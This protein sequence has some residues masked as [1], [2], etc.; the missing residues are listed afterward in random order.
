MTPA[1]PRPRTSR[2]RRVH[3]P[4][5]TTCGAHD[6]GSEGAGGSTAA[7]AAVRRLAF[8]GS[9]AAGSGEACA[10]GTS[11]WRG[12]A[13]LGKGAAAAG[14][15]VG[16]TAGG[17][18][19]AVGTSVASGAVADVGVGAVLAKAGNSASSLP[20]MLR[21]TRKVPSTI[22]TDAAHTAL[23]AS[24]RDAWRRC[25]NC[26]ASSLSGWSLAAVRKSVAS[27]CRMG[28]KLGSG[29]ARRC[30]SGCG[31]NWGSSGGSSCGSSASRGTVS[32]GAGSAAAGSATAGCCCSSKSDG[33]GGVFSS[34]A[35]QLQQ[36]RAVTPLSA[37]QFGQGNK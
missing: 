6:A 2:S 11:T 17:A 20:V 21:T 1:R 22:T 24:R 3:R 8:T 34:G 16:R 26:N 15:I 13:I 31:S 19:Y 10:A 7:G 32:S 30:S 18:T 14:S 27:S 25:M 29:S 36:T 23:V 37:A 28:K 12:A 35:S 4:S 33:R 5:A 9:A